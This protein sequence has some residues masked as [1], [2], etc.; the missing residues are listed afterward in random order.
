ML[1]DGKFGQRRYQFNTLQI[2]AF[3]ACAAI[4]L[5]IL[6]I[7][8]TIAIALLVSVIPALPVA[9]WVRKQWWSRTKLISSFAALSALF[10]FLYALTL[11]PALKLTLAMGW[12]IN[13]EVP[14]SPVIWL[15]RNTA[16]KE[17]IERYL[18]LW[19]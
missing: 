6:R 12:T 10:F 11:G 13:L 14:Y 8:S 17:P 4:F 9:L 5:A 16:L 1:D 2:L 15:Y 18:K 19:V 3:I 7:S